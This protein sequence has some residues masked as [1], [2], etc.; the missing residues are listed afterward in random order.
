MLSQDFI[1]GFIADNPNYFQVYNILGDYM[2]SK[3]EIDLAKE[4]WKKS[5]MLEIARVEERDEIIKKVE[6][7]D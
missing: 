1:D 3:N 2:L 5:L 6:K 4:Y 7:Y